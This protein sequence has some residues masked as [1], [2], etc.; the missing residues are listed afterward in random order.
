MEAVSKKMQRQR[1][2][3]MLAE[4]TCK[5][6]RDPFSEGALRSTMKRQ[7]ERQQKREK[8][9]KQGQQAYTNRYGVRID[10][11]VFSE[12]EPEH[13]PSVP[14]PVL[15]RTESYEEVSNDSIDM[16][17]YSSTHDILIAGGEGEE[18]FTRQNTEEYNLLRFDKKGRPV[19]SPRKQAA[20]KNAPWKPEKKQK[21]KFGRLLKEAV[22]KIMIY[23]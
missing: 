18:G 16:G 2:D 15:G 22:A 4:K 19:L 5:K 9:I 6:S 13:S 23:Y 8:I 21:K 17:A 20:Q 10:K 11:L 7:Q 12:D 3:F 1:V 14:P